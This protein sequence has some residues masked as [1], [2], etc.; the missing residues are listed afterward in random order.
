M[1][2]R[3]AI[4]LE[5]ARERLARLWVILGGAI[6]LFFV[7]GTLGG[8][9]APDPGAVWSWLLPSILPSL[10]TIVSVW[11]YAAL[12]PAKAQECVQKSF[13]H[14][15]LGISVF[16][17]LL[18]PLPVFVSPFTGTSCLDLMK[19]SNLWLGPLQGLVAAAL[20]VLFASKQ[21][22]KGAE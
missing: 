3:E 11:G 13:Y 20:G 5:R 6:V 2:S 15:A 8:K 12:N 21:K 1:A 4:P 14:V 22:A 9:Y 18:I 10:G 16:Y 19:T 7:A 17:L